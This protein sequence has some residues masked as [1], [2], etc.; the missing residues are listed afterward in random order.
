[1]KSVKSETEASKIIN[2]MLD[3]RTAG[4][5]AA[6]TRQM[7]QH[8]AMRAE[9]GVNPK[10]VAAGIKAHVARIRNS[11]ANTTTAA[12]VIEAICN[13]DSPAKKAHATRKLNAYVAQ[14]TSKGMKEV[15]VR[16]A[17]KAHVTRRLQAS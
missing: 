10:M 17:I 9:Q 3:A 7:N 6:A 8:A 12:M 15:Q 14:Q 13:A 4:Q 11:S 1:M 2:A 16:A 5:K